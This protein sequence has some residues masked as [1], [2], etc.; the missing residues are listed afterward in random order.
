MHV[1]SSQGCQRRFPPR[2]A[3]GE[4]EPMRLF[5]QYMEPEEPLHFPPTAPCCW[6]T[7]MAGQ[8]EQ[9][10]TTSCGSL[11]WPSP[12]PE[13]KEKDHHRFPKPSEDH[14]DCSSHFDL[15]FR[16]STV[17]FIFTAEQLISQ[18]H[19]EWIS[20]TVTCS[21]TL[22]CWNELLFV[23]IGLWLLLHMSI[24]GTDVAYKWH[25]SGDFLKRSIRPYICSV[26][27]PES[28]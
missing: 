9:Q 22:Q 19:L 28:G 1:G 8:R 14:K 23:H 25:F 20:S 6:P 2:F 27:H 13:R 4:E 18:V 10:V 15:I 16:R 11:M 21:F 24:S 5:E 3:S 12:F 7:F 17:C 26:C